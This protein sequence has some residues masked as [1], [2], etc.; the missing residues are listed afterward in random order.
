MAFL[1]RNANRGSVS[2]GP[3]MDYEVDNSVKLQ[4]AGVNSEFF[5]FEDIIF[6]YN[7]YKL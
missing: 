7:F 2:T 1:E 3:D 6:K 5:N 4:T